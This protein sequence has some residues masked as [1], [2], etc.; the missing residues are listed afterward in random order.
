M[1]S[2]CWAPACSAVQSEPADQ[3]RSGL[4]L[5]GFAIAPFAPLMSSETPGLVGSAH[6]AN[7]MGLQFTGASLGMALLPW[8]GGILA[9]TLG[10]EGRSPAIRL[11]DRAN[12][13]PALRGDRLGATFKRP[14]VKPS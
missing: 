6:T 14:V 9:E 5:I 3:F 10:L 1:S 11:P 4:A 2:S 12:H 7:A 8:L 13:L